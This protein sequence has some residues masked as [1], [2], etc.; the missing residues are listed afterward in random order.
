MP[1]ELTFVFGETK[2][3]EITKNI[4]DDGIVHYLFS[5]RRIFTMT[6]CEECQKKLRILEGYR[7]PAQGARFLVCRKC[8]DK[9]A[10]DMEGWSKFYLTNTFT[11]EAS[12]AEIHKAWNDNIS[13]DPSLQTWFHDLWHKFEVN[14]I[15]GANKKWLYR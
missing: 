7:H 8:F 2:K 1:Y 12:T 9:V 3:S 13:N 15:V 4:K 6:N 14:R 5:T 10:G 11:A